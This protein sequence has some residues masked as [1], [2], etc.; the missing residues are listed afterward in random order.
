[1]A[2]VGKHG[3]TLEIRW[4]LKAVMPS[5][6]RGKQ[7]KGEH[8]NNEVGEAWTLFV[9]GELA[10]E[11]PRRVDFN[12]MDLETATGIGPRK[13]AEELF[14]DLFLWL[15]DQRLISFTQVADEGNAFDVSLTDRGFDAIGH[16]LGIEKRK[17]GSMLK[18]IA[19][20]AATEAGRTTITETIGQLIGALVRGVAGG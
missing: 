2:F 1:M 18:K 11:W 3:I 10:D 8:T 20:G 13:D 7:V 5:S 19:A 16:S 4:A 14:D 17:T 9:L 6:W 12:A 15:R